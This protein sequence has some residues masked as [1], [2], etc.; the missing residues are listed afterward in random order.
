MLI[1]IG[2]TLGAG[3][4]TVA[5]YLAAKHNFIYVSVRAFFAAELMKAGM[6]V[7]REKILEIAAKIRAEHGQTYPIEQLLANTIKSR[8]IV[9][10]S[11]RTVSEAQYLK[12][13]GDALWLVDA[14]IKIRYPRIRARASEIDNISFEEFAAQEQKE[15][16][17]ADPNLPSL[18]DLKTMAG[19]SFMNNGT[20]QELF[21]EVDKALLKLQ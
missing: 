10:E 11:I 17:S 7:N 5:Q 13:H 14:D 8:N 15:L 21:A 18:E 6:A 20:K 1:G 9:I 2:G 16:K 12:A 4:G 3:K 19:W